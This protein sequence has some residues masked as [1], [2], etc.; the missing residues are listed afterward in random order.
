MQIGQ[1][2]LRRLVGPD[3]SL[4]QIVFPHCDL[5]GGIVP[6][7]E[8]G[9]SPFR[10]CPE[11][12][13][14]GRLYREQRQY[15][16]IADAYREAFAT[17][18]GIQSA[19]YANTLMVELGHRLYFAAGSEKNIKLTTKDDFALFRAYLDMEKTAY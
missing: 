13:K 17:G 7:A 5:R 2:V 3:L 9:R 19:T 12:I 1:H 18:V 11:Q 4:R 16:I 14:A 15:G 6:D 10:Q 8:N